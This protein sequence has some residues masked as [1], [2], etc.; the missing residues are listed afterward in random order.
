MKL[1][2]TDAVALVHRMNQKM[3]MTARILMPLTLVSFLLLFLGA[4][5]ESALPTA[6]GKGE[7][8]GINAISSSPPLSFKIEERTIGQVTFKGQTSN[9]Y[10]NLNY[11]FNF[12][13]PGFGDDEERR[14]GSAQFDLTADT[15][16]IVAITGTTNA[17]SVAHWQQPRRIWDGSES[18]AGVAFAHVSGKTGPVDMYFDTSGVAPAPGQ[19][20]AS[21]SFGEFEPATDL[22]SGSYVITVTPQGDPNT[23]IHQSAQLNLAPATS[24]IVTVFD[25]DA[26][27]TSP[28]G[29][30]L[31]AGA[32]G[33]FP[34]PDT[35]SPISTRLINAAFDS[36]NVDMY[37]D[38]NFSAP[39]FGNVAFSS[40][41]PRADMHGGSTTLTF[42]P[43]GNPGATLLQSDTSNSAA[44]V[45]TYLFAGQAGN[46][47]VNNLEDD[48]RSI[49][50]FAKLRIMQGSSNVSPADIYII[51]SGDDITNVFPNFFAISTGGSTDYRAFVADTYEIVVTENTSKTILGRLSNVVAAKGSVIEVLVL[52][53]ADPNAL[54]L[55]VVAP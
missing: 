30:Q 21:L 33:S 20:R 9:V 40:D 16:H 51:K 46:Y 12:D 42:T 23:I 48:P 53:T 32:S 26:S 27:Q 50:T 47:L 39:L 43:T 4:C 2:T 44:T 37:I 6:T 18:V 25:T 31:L 19:A 14:L 28:L 29:L 36:G 17:A 55:R 41:T 35:S 11:T 13:L 8:R 49:D 24:Y 5:A 38:Q 7:I 34:A 10:D 3:L 54:Q 22:P 45:H 1:A 15:E 52:D